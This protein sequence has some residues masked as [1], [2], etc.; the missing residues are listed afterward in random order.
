MKTCD[1]PYRCGRHGFYFPD[2]DRKID[3]YDCPRVLCEKCEKE[4]TNSEASE[5][6]VFSR[7]GV[8]LY[9]NV[10]PQPGPIRV[11]VLEDDTELFVNNSAIIMVQRPSGSGFSVGAVEDV[12]VGDEVKY[13]YHMGDVKFSIQPPE[14]NIVKLVVYK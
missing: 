3:D 6:F 2:F 5:P 14:Y 4:E 9:I 11:L 1:S 8:V 7:A 13:F 10:P 12:D